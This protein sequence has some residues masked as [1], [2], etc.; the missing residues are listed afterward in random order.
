MSAV[1][2]VC[3]RSLSNIIGGYVDLRGFEINIDWR[4][5]MNRNVVCIGAGYIG[6]PTMAV[7]AKM[8]PDR[9]VIVVDINAKKEE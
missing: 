8:N 2:V 5:E 7:I 1:L 4:K 6:G 3:G 9:K